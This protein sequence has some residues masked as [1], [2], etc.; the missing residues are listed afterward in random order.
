MGRWGVYES[1][2]ASHGGG[3][4]GETRN[5]IE[6]RPA[7]AGELRSLAD[8]NEQFAKSNAAEGGESSKL[9]APEEEARRALGY[10]E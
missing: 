1:S 5:R 10:I 7:I 4:P 2:E 9:S 8:A 3:C 6:E